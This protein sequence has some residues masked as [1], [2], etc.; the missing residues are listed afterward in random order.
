[1]RCHSFRANYAKKIACG[2]RVLPNLGRPV[3]IF[4]KIIG[5]MEDRGLRPGLMRLDSDGVM[6][7]I[8]GLLGF[9]AKSSI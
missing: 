5:D 9:V 8:L 3:L 7:Y 6:P 4:T 2:K 1:M